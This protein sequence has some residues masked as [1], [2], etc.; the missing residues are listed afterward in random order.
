MKIKICG[1][2]NLE[3]LSALEMLKPDYFGFICYPKSPR[4]FAR[5]ALPHFE[6]SKKVG[7]FVNEDIYQILKL[8]NQ[9]QLDA[10]QLH[11]DEQDDYVFQLKSQLPQGVEIFKAI[12]I[13]TKEDFKKVLPYESSVNLIILDTKTELRGGSGQKFNWN[14]LD[15]YDSSLPFLLSGGIRDV[16]AENIVDL[17]KSHDKMHGVDINSKFEIEPGL[18]DKTKVERFINSIEKYADRY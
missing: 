1:M 14:L 16:D 8:Q 10:I 9:F 4:N 12:S 6:Y 2:N 11:G 15:H 18:K 7:V 13:S 5:F 17:F 3:N